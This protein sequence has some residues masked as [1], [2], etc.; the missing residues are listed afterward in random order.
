MALIETVVNELQDLTVHTIAGEVTGDEII[1]KTQ[2]GLTRPY[3]RYV[4]WDFTQ[5]H[6]TDLSIEKIQQILIIGKKL[7]EARKTGKT[8]IV[9]P[10]DLGFGLGRMYEAYSEIESFPTENRVF[11]TLSQAWEWLGLGM[12]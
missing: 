2:D 9:V 12:V 3:T 6:A 4:L 5:A 7:A 1:E 11:R 10:Q 8:A